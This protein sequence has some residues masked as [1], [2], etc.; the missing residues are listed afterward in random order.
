M[1]RKKQPFP[2]GN[3]R[4]AQDIAALLAPWGI[5]QSMGRVFGYLLLQREPVSLERIAQDLELSKTSAWK[6]AQDLA[7]CGHAE[8]QRVAG[9]RHGRVD[10]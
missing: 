8:R 1:S 7:N 10:R 6:M 2:A 3:Q 4:F 9:R 5:S